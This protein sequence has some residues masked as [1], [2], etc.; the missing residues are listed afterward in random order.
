VSAQDVLSAATVGGAACLG[1]KSAIGEITE[2]AQADIA[3]LSLGGSHQVPI[4][5]PVMTTIFSSSGRDVLMTVVAGQ[6]IYKDGCVLTVD[7]ERLR[8]RMGEISAKL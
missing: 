1:M 2:G 7:E 4:Y 6:E 8:A 3:V 5:D